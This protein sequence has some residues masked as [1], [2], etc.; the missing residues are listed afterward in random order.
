MTTTTVPRLT[1]ARLLAAGLAV[2]VVVVAVVVVLR[3]SGERT[4]PYLSLI[5]I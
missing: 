3:V 1:R 2:G 5:H 4:V